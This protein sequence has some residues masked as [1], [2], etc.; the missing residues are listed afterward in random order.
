MWQDFTRIKK[1]LI[2]NAIYMFKE[3]LFGY[4]AEKGSWETS[5]ETVGV[6]IKKRLLRPYKYE[7]SKL[8]LNN[9]VSSPSALKMLKENKAATHESI[10]Y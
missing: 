2:S 9:L 10:K 5:H 7:Q 3:L 6:S 1:S 8:K 4:F